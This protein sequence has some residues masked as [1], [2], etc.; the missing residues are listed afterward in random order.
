M[1]MAAESIDELFEAPETPAAARGCRSPKRCAGS[2]R[3]RS[4]PPAAAARRSSSS[5]G[6]PSRSR[7]PTAGPASE[8]PFPLDLVPRII[9]AGEWTVIKRGL[10]QRIRALNAFIDDV[11]HRREIVRE[12]IVPW[13]LVVSRSHFSRVVHGVRPPGGIYCHVS[14]CDLVRDAD[15]SWKVLEDNVRTPSG[16]S[17]V[18]E[19]RLAMMRLVP[20]LFAGY[21]V[22]PVD[23]YPAVLLNALRAVAPSGSREPD[24]RGLDARA[25]QQ[26]LLRARLPGAPDGRGARRGVRP[27][28]ARRRLLHAHHRGARPRRR[29]LPPHRRRLHRP[30]RVPPRLAARRAR[31]HAGLPVGHDRDRQRDRH[32]CGRRQ[33]GLPLRPGHDPLLPRGRPDPRQRAHVPARRPRAARARARADRHPGDQADRRVRRQGRLHRPARATTRRSPC[34]PS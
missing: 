16:I 11:Y 1:A 6:S 26:R 27:R 22:R 31:P 24:G 33:G 10:A 21:R 5:R 28:G 34:R 19:N 3:P 15:G 12:G 32:R 2:A 17:Y 23:H 18:L 29:H 25:G 8:R 9:P 7:A 4:R 30:A 13:S 20:E 14:G